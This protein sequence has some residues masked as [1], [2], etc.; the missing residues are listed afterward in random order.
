M[1]KM[2]PVGLSLALTALI[3]F[4]SPLRAEDVGG[5]VIV[6]GFVSQGFLKSSANKFLTTD[7]DE[8]IV[9]LHGGRPQ[10]HRAARCRRSGWRPS[11]SPA[12]WD[13]RATTAW[14]WTG[15]SAS[16]GPGTRSASGPDG[17]SS[18]SAS[19]TPSRTPTWPG[20]RSSNRAGSIPRSA[21]TSRAPIDGGGIFRTIRLRRRRLPQYEGSTRTLDLDDT[22]ALGRATNQIAAAAGARPGEPRASRGSRTTSSTSKGHSKQAYTT[23]VEWHP[24]LAGLRLRTGLQGADI[25]F[26]RRRR[27][28]PSVLLPRPH[29]RGPE[30]PLGREHGRSPA[31]ALR[32]VRPG[33][34][35]A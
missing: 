26:G 27:T 33:E 20:R 4:A 7:S 21:A 8:G 19:T 32:R 29:A 31:R 25:D 28:R 24:P 35:C 5:G 3:A 12:T 18:R 23:Y 34:A 9:C 2:W 22:Y 10:L 17:S 16:I 14:S 30:R 15:V 6:R 1:T 11:S 13:G